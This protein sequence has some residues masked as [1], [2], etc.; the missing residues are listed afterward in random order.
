MMVSNSFV[1]LF[2]AFKV[3]ATLGTTGACSFDDLNEVY[4]AVP[5]KMTLYLKLNNIFRLLMWQASIK[6]GCTLMQLM[7]E[8]RLF[9]RN[10]VAG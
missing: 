2:N 9:V 4:S 5:E 8:A 7:R 10:I 1:I 6:F 3:C